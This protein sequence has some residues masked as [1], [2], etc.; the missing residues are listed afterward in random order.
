MIEHPCPEC[1]GRGNVEQEESFTVTIPPGIEEGMAL[2]IPGKGMASLEVDS[3]SGDLFVVVRTRRDRCSGH[4]EN[5]GCLVVV[6]TRRD[7]RFERAGA[8]LLRQHTIS[9]TDAILGTTLEVPTLD[10]SV[11]VTVPP[12]IQPGEVLRI[13]GKGLPEFGSSRHGELYLRIEVA[14]RRILRVRNGIYT[15]VCVR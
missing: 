15:S 1:Q 9:L 12:G 14:S 11:S 4:A 3:A 13:R 5:P 7:L 6:R 10:G 2:R 8:D